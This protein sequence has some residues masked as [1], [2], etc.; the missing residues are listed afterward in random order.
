MILMDFGSNYVVVN[1]VLRTKDEVWK[2][3]YEAFSDNLVT[4]L[5]PDENNG[6]IPY[7][8][9][10]LGTRLNRDYYA[11]LGHAKCFE[12]INEL[13][14]RD[15]RNSYVVKDFGNIQDRYLIANR[16]LAKGAGIIMRTSK[17]NFLL[18][19][20]G[21]SDDIEKNKI[22]CDYALKLI[23]L[24]NVNLSQGCFQ[25]NGQVIFSLEAFEEYCH[26]LK[27]NDKPRKRQLQVKK[28]K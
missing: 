22:M 7:P 18:I 12:K 16:F 25:I 15:K 26:L 17:D 3:Y 23:K 6:F 19:F 2:M 24:L 21:F 1:G 9:L 27:S 4:I 10:N 5:I 14:L 8:H 28:K 13:L 20:S 11:S